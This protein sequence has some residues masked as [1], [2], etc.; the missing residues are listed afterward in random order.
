MTPVT[1]HYF[2]RQIEDFALDHYRRCDTIAN[3]DGCTHSLGQEPAGVSA[4]QC[5]AFH[6]DT[7][8]NGAMESD[9]LLQLKFMFLYFSKIKKKCSTY[10]TANQLG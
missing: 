10:I 8:E 9:F 1:S 3:K 4:T 6:R 7:G 2:Q 5:N